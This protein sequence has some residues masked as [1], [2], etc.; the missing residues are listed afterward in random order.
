[1]ADEWYFQEGEQRTGPISA[2][3]LRQLAA[4]GGITPDTL[5]WK[6]GLPNWIPAKSVKGLFG[7]STNATP[8]TPSAPRPI[9]PTTP[10]RAINAGSHPFDL[11][12]H[13]AR[14]ACPPELPEAIS[15]SAG[16]AGVYALYAAALFS[17]LVG[18]ILAIRTNEFSALGVFAASAFAMI[19]LQYTAHRLLHASAAAVQTN[20]S[21]LSSYAVPD[22]IFVLTFFG[23]LG[24]VGWLLWQSIAVGSLNLALGAVAAFVVGMFIAIVSLHPSEI[25]V[26]TKPDCQAGEDAVGFL[27]FF[28]KLF[29]RCAPIFFVAAIVYGT[30]EL[31]AAGVSI[32][33]ADK[34]MAG[35]AGFR[36]GATVGLLIGAAAIPFYAYLLT[37]LY[38]LSLDIVSAIVSMPSKLDAIAKRIGED[39]RDAP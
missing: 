39:S 33:Q 15:R 4:S 8:T 37:I 14:N 2:A 22:C 24:G 23:T 12:V 28:V 31:A 17:V 20:A 25:R 9:N 29:L 19:V 13:A 16:L 27:T 7:I 6:T 10:P 18:F 38:Y 3:A 30:Y 34:E 26:R 5:I 21:F 36:A 1:M 35:F 11:L 32:L